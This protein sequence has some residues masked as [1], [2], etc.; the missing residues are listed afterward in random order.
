MILCGG[1]G[2]RLREQTETVPKPMVEIGGRPILWHIM[3]MYARH[4][5]ADFILCLGY[6]GHIIKEYFL[7]Y[8]SM[9]SDFTVRLGSADDVTYHDV[10]HDEDKW[11]VTLTDTGEATMTGARVLRASR[12]LERDGGTFAV[13]YGD[14]VSDIDLG[15]A[16]RFHRTQGRLATVAGV[17]IPSRFGVIVR[18]GTRVTSFSEKPQIEEGLVSGGLF[19][20]ERGFLNYLSDDANCV[21]EQAPMRR[22]ASDGRMSVYEHT[23]FWQCMDT[24]RDWQKLQALWDSGK[25]PW[26]TWT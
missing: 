2:T 11:R 7:N 18:D 4:G 25:C 6:K 5:M 23:G 1:F 8:A 13:T 9:N 17:R 15:A 3:K 12:Y 19:F 24:L 21:L 14:G 26:R 10:T 22:C 20:F 16:L